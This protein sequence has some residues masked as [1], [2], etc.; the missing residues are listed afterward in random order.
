MKK[1]SL[2]FFALLALVMYGCEDNNNNDVETP[3]GLPGNKVFAIYVTDD[4]LKYFA[5]D[6]GIASFDGTQWAVHNDNPKVSKG[7]IHDMDFEQ[8]TYGPELW[9]GTNEGVNVITLPVDATSGATIYS[10]AN[11]PGIFPGQPTL[12]GDTVLAVKVDGNNIRWFGTSEGLSAFSGNQ[13]P[14]IDFNGH[15]FAGFFENNRI[16]S[17]DFANDTIYIGTMGGG[18]ARMITSAPDAISGASPF[19]IPWSNL[20]SE[21]ILSV[22][23]DGH[24]QWFGSD[25]GLA[26]HDGT[27][28]KENWSH[29][30]VS[31]GLANQYV[32]AINKDNDGNMWFGTQVGISKYDGTDF[33]NYTTVQGLAG[34][35]VFCITIDKDGT[36]WFGTDNGASHFNGSSFTNYQAAD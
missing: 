4:G 27:E 3:A 8:T 6:K 24:S 7:M 19:E 35:N 23:V 26:R 32:Q 36:I 12:A 34:N 29:F 2:A 17:I 5:T 20:P 21:N 22:F 31:H 33:I 10:K 28:A 18:I 30:Y 1:L 15:Y 11:T 14:A 13:W 9:L 25:E 16:T